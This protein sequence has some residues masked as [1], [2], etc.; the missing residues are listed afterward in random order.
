[1]SWD[2]PSAA[3]AL[4]D[5]LMAATA[6]VVTVHDRPPSTL[7][8]PALVVSYPTAVAKHTPTFAID[9]AELAVLG[10]VGVEAGD[11]LDGLLEVATDAIEGDPTLAGAVQYCKPTEWRN[12]RIMASAGASLLVAEIA[13]EIRM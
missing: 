2:R 3:A 9:Q 6:D 1:V 13:L 4:V 10:A 7:N 5:V 11:D 8:A 12:W